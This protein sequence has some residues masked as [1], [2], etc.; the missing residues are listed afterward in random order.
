MI[1]GEVQATGRGAGQDG[2]PDRG[3]PAWGNASRGLPRRLGFALMAVMA[4]CSTQSTRQ[5]GSAEEP[6][7]SGNGGYSLLTEVRTLELP[8]SSGSNRFLNGWRA[9]RDGDRVVLSTMRGTIEVTNLES[10]PRRLTLRLAP[11][12]TIPAD[13]ELVVGDQ[14]VAPES[15]E[16]DLV[17]SLPPEI[18]TGRHVLEIRS[19]EMLRVLAG[20]VTPALDVGAAVAVTENGSVKQE[21][22]SVVARHFWAGEGDTFLVSIAE[23]DAS[24]RCSVEVD[25]Q[26]IEGRRRTLGLGRTVYEYSFRENASPDAFRSTGQEGLRRATL[27]L[28]NSM[29]DATCLWERPRLVRSKT[30]TEAD[31]QQEPERE[32]L[33]PRLVV[34]YVLD[35]MRWDTVDETHTILGLAQEGFRFDRHRSVAP[36]TLPST[37]ALMT[38][39][40]WAQQGGVPLGPS[41][42][43][44]GEA[45]REAGYRTA[46]FSN[47]PY[48]S[49]R[50][51]VARGFD[52]A[53][54]APSSDLPYHDDANRVHRL[55][56]DWLE[57]LTDDDRAFMYVHTLHP[58]NP[59]SPPQDIEDE[60][61]QGIDSDMGGDT[62]TLLDIQ[63]G[64]LRP[65]Q[66]DRDR[67]A[68]LYLGGLLY[69]DRELESFLK[70]LHE[71]Y[72]PEEVLFVVTSDHGEELFEHR[73]VL[74]GYTLYEE[75]LRVPL[76]FH[77]PGNIE[78]GRFDGATNTLDVRATLLNVI[79]SLQGGRGGISLTSVLN[80]GRPH[81]AL[82]DRI[83]F[84]AA[85]SLRGGIYS[86]QRGPSKLIWAPRR[87]LRWGVGT[88]PARNR[89]IEYFF[90]LHTDGTEQVNL[91]GGWDYLWLREELMNWV[92]ERLVSTDDGDSQPLDKKTEE[93]LRALGYLGGE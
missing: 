18:G 41:D 16:A 83:H 91:V 86:A 59:Y 1:I 11:E 45:F 28:R 88:G 48:V 44:L 9:R 73:G 37:K 13:V 57:T 52:Q 43:T 58:H 3:T 29:P 80:G 19:T 72:M 50:F 78:N 36:N 63:K 33:S 79:G 22:N 14:L 30:D 39:R 51:G 89:D 49:A 8:S 55:A 77:W 46:L 27:R 74:H 67:V 12:A 70:A 6:L 85:A 82:A 40:V 68:A 62:R 90:D 76:I 34:L 24:E 21:G 64:K 20:A 81:P 4:A 32:G 2:R 92:G 26:P 15:R 31:R 54:D 61:T 60:V 84:A 23:N 65:D 71:R 93:R 38:G 75:A 53:S 10:R 35:A 42:P 7:F 66:D 5:G 25:E 47:N 69:N 56:T 17:F 87:G